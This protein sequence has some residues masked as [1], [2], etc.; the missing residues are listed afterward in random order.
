MLQ[1]FLGP[2]VTTRSKLKGRNEVL[3]IF[4]VLDKRRGQGF[5][6]LVFI[7]GII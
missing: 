1:V 6:F 3:Y 4:C 5:L 2:D 7:S